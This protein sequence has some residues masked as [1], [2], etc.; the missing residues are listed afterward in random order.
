MCCCM[1]VSWVRSAVTG[2][3]LATTFLAEATGAP[4]DHAEA[5]VTR[6]IGKKIDWR[7]RRITMENHRRVVNLDSSDVTAYVDVA[8][9]KLIGYRRSAPGQRE[10]PP[11]LSEEAAS[12]KAR[13]FL[14]RVGVSVQRPWVLDRQRY[15][16]RGSAGREYSFSWRKYVRGVQLPAMLD[17]AVDADSGEIRTYQLIDDP[18]VVP[19]R[20]RFTAAEAAQSI[21]QRR[22][23]AQPVVESARASIGYQPV[24]PGPQ[25][26]LWDV[27][28][29]DH[30]GADR[31]QRRQGAPQ[32]VLWDVRLSEPLSRAL[33]P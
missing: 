11:R 29:R 26:V 14:Q 12:A 13:S 16:D 27:R 21:V 1:R 3:L 32:A 5:V 33:T 7:D 8:T 9:G 4:N 30:G 6:V 17:L 24:Y 31:S 22:G 15:F 20:A 23:M 18:G 10:G 2:F 25:A 19:I 28:L